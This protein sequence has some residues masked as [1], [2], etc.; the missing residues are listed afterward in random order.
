MNA[1]LIR[2]GASIDYVPQTDVE[3]GSI[4][5]Q[6]SIVGVVNHKIYAGK[7]GSIETSGIYAV[8]KAD[9]TDAFTVG[10]PVYLDSSTKAVSI[11]AGEGLFGYAVRASA[12]GDE[13]V[14]A[15]L[16]FGPATTDGS[17]A[18]AP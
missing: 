1:I 11:D 16:V 8:E 17:G 12:N 4:I 10:A 3:A 7:L 9:S 6:G 5:V 18:T 13:T 14:E 15:Y 2:N